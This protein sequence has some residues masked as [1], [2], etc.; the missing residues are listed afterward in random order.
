MPYLSI[1]SPVY[2]TGEILLALV[3]QLE[4]VLTPINKDYEIIL[5]D[6]GS[7]DSSWSQVLRLCERDSRIKGVLLSRNFGQHAA[8]TAGLEMA[9]GEWIVVMD[10]DL[11]DLPREISRLHAKA[12][13]GY[14]V[15]VARRS[16]RKDSF[17]RRGV[18]RIFNSLITRWTGMKADHTVAN[19]GIYSSRVI[20]E[21][22]RFK[23][24]VQLFPVIVNWTGFRRGWV[25][26]EHGERAS[27]KSEY[28]LKKLMM[29]A[30]NSILAY[31]D[32]PLRY[33]VKLGLVI[34]LLS[35][36]LA[37]VTLIRYLRG[38]IIVAGYTSLILSIWFLSGLI[39]LTLGLVGL[40]IGRTFEEVKKRPRFIVDRVV[41][42]SSS[43]Q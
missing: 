37:I 28:N 29:L 30:L 11:Q 25:D 35:F 34:S 15:V 23:E 41:D 14:E 6:D 42:H 33:V 38:D 39:L 5:V 20:K 36:V 43:Q 40:Y 19:F 3:G 26:V 17:F 16:D 9:K 21:V 8:L 10:S 24:S 22:L 7:P 13:E 2:K 32:K 12:L 27:G 4:E 1:V 18:S 31:S